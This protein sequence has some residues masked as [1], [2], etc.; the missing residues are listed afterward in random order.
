MNAKVK[1]NMNAHMQK[2]IR[3][4]HQKN[5]ENNRKR[6]KYFTFHINEL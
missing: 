5:I 6:G 1:H 3:K 4:S 2:E